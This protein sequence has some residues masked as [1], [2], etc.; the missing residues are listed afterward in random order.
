MLLLQTFL[1]LKFKVI[2]Y[3]K[4]YLAVHEIMSF[5]EYICNCYENRKI[6]HNNSIYKIEIKIKIFK[7]K[8]SKY[9]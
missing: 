2:L 7:S 6:Y 9:K 5:T 4:T 8:R 1:Y 3:R